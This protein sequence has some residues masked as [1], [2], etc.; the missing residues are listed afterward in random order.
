MQS[1]NRLSEG[2]ALCCKIPDLEFGFLL[3]SQ[4]RHP[5]DADCMRC[6]LAGSTGEERH[7]GLFFLP[8]KFC[9]M[10]DHLM[11]PVSI[12][13]L[14]GTASVTAVP[15]STSTPAESACFCAR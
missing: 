2:R 7:N 8:P 9:S 1:R 13:I 12:C 15:S 10:T 5:A 4:K 3:P 11:T 6:F 14:I